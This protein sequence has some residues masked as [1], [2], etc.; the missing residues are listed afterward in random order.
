MEQAGAWLKNRL[1][2]LPDLKEVENN[3]AL[4]NRELQID[5]TD[6]AYFLGLSHGDI[7]NQVRQGFFG[8]EVQRLQKG[9]DEVRVWVRYPSS[10][11]INLG[12]LE[13]MKVKLNDGSEYPLTGLATY[14]F[15]RGVAGIRHYNGAREVTVSADLVDPVADVGAIN[16]NIEENIA[17]E[18][19][20]NFPGVSVDFGGQSREA[21]KAAQQLATYF[22]IAVFII[23]VIIMVH[24]R[25]YYQGILVMIMIP[26]GWIGA[27][28]G[29][30][31]Q[32]IPVSLLS[33]WGMIALSGVIINDAVVF[34]A[35][36]N[37]LIKEGSSVREAA[38]EAGLARFRA[39]LLT[40]ITTVLGLFPLLSETSVQ[41][42]ILIPMAVSMAYGVLIG[43]F[44]ILVFFPVLIMAFNDVRVYAKW[45][46][47]GQRPTPREV[48]RVVIDNAKDMNLRLSADL[49]EAIQE[50]GKSTNGHHQPNDT[51]LDKQTEERPVLYP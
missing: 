38:Y 3:I 10:G 51:P 16:T 43:T 24:F 18:L 7:T 42:K 50:T 41:A 2:N 37:S 27:M 8:E 5:L 45:L 4:G 48:E 49:E 20:A 11:R 46:W 31:I 23:F 26:L 36:F 47:T 35:K 22:G 30:L 29:H 12:Q 17:P 21:D 25:S 33:A 34:L 44:I 28:F 13:S 32:G 15:D 14:A 19:E 1:E 39:I 40:S 6:K 9:K